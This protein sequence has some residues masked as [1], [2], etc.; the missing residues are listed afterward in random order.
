MKAFHNDIEIKTKYVNRVMEHQRLD[1]LV[2]G[3]T[4]VNGKGCAVSC[5]LDMV[6]DHSR[7]PI[8]MGIPEWMAMLEDSLFEGM[9]LEKSKTFPEMFL[10]AINVGSD[11]EKVKTPFIIKVLER[12]LRSLD[13]CE[14]DKENNPEVVAA[15]D[16]SKKAVNMMIDA[17]KMGDESAARLAESTARSA[18]LPATWSATWEQIANDL[19]ECIEDCDKGAE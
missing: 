2:K 19:I 14:F 6:Y 10:K 5:T 16:G 4:G 12:N 7:Y 3:E 15:I 1:N 8:E 9:S 11:L 18:A 17:Y 13:S